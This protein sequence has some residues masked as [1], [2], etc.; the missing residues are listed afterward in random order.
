MI[1]DYAD[2]IPFLTEN[3]QDLGE[4]LNEMTNKI[5][6]RII[7]HTYKNFNIFFILFWACALLFK[8]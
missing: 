8:I 3:E 2:D 6:I 4:I 5:L 1:L 7:R